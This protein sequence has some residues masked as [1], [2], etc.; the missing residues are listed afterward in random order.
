MSDIRSPLYLLALGPAGRFV[1][2]DTTWR[3]RTP[4]QIHRRNI[5]CLTA[6]A[7]PLSAFASP[8]WRLQVLL[9]RRTRRS[10]SVLTTL[11]PAVRSPP[12]STGLPTR[13]PRT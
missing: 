4:A 6:A 12:I 1:E 10:R 11:P 7:W 2:V 3:G 5:P 13:R 8:D 9:S